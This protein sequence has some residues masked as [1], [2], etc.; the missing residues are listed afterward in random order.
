MTSRV[1]K[2]TDRHTVDL[3]EGDKVGISSKEDLVELLRS[4]EVL[5]Y[6]TRT[7]R[8]VSNLF[9]VPL[10]TGDKVVEKVTTLTFAPSSATETM[11][12]GSSKIM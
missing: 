5:V 6:D 10:P 9:G 12:E 11:P 7:K 4:G 1:I 3:D 2:I 8:F